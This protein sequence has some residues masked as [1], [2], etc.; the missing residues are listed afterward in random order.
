MLISE[1]ELFSLGEDQFLSLDFSGRFKEVNSPRECF[2]K[3]SFW[4]IITITNKNKS[5]AIPGKR[6]WQPT[7]VFLPGESHGQSS[8][9]GYS[10]WGHEELDMNEQLTSYN[11]GRDYR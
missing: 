3:V 2:L 1:K 10:P 5:L 6:K 4:Q 8:L 9:A 11:M 7:P